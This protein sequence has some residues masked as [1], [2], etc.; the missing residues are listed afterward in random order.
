MAE[1][2]KKSPESSSDRHLLLRADRFNVE[3]IGWDDPQGTRRWKDVVR[4]PGA[5]VVLPLL[6]DGRICLIRNQ[7]VS[8]G[9][10]LLEVPAGT[11]DPGESPPVCAKRELKEETGYV[12]GEMDSLGWFYVSPGIMDERMH[13]FVA[14]DLTHTSPNRMPDENIENYL[15]A[16]DDAMQRV[17]AGEIHDAKTMIALLRLPLWRESERQRNA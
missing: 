14:T 3:R 4:H 1:N 15:I 7:R 2:R 13:L 17:L 8:V 10:T 16:Y 12:A 6:E 9:E 5:V 11:M